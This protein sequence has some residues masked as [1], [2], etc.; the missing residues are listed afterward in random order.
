MSS[1]PPTRKRRVLPLHPLQHLHQLPI[2]QHGPT[3]IPPPA[4][5]TLAHL[6]PTA[7]G[8]D[9]AL[10]HLP[11]VLSGEAGAIREHR[12]S[13]YDP[14]GRVM[15]PARP[16]PSPRQDLDSPLLQCRPEIPAIPEITRPSSQELLERRWIH[17]PEH[18]QVLRLIVV[19][20]SSATRVRDL[21]G[22]PVLPDVQDGIQQVLRL[23]LL[24]PA[25]A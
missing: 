21:I 23:E 10:V 1:P 15:F 19:P 4:T 20:G 24:E 3:E 11:E 17:I 9:L 22:G 2:P 12:C 16:D 14:D 18:G 7:A 6:P 25:T 13:R 8:P 5:I